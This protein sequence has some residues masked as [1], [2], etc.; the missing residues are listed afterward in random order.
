MQVDILSSNKQLYKGEAGAL[1]L[2]GIDGQMEILNNH[3]PLFAILEQ[4]DIRIDGKKNFPINYG[5]V[6]VSNNK[7]I[8]LIKLI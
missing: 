3:A 1:S 7:V 8:I 6:H 4:G 2:P 5:I